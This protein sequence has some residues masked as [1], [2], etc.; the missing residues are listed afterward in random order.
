VSGADKRNDGKEWPQRGAIDA[1][2][3]ET[4]NFAAS[5]ARNRIAAL[6]WREAWI[7]DYFAG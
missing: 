7:F 2:K 3:E 1:K 4:P 5:E 6:S